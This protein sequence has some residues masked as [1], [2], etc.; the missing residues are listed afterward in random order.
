MCTIYTSYCFPGTGYACWIVSTAVAAQ[1]FFD[2]RRGL[3]M[4]VSSSGLSIGVLVWPSFMRFTI[5]TYTFRGALVL[6]AAANM[7]GFVL[8]ALLRQPHFEDKETK[9]AT[10]VEMET[11]CVGS[12]ESESRKEDITVAIK[13]HF[14]V[15]VS[16]PPDEEYKEKSLLDSCNM[17]KEVSKN[18]NQS[19]VICY[20]DE[21]LQVECDHCLEKDTSRRKGDDDSKAH[22]SVRENHSGDVNEDGWEDIDLDAQLNHHPIYRP[23]CSVGDTQSAM[24]T[25]DDNATGDVKRRQN[26]LLSCLTCITNVL[27]F[28]LLK[29]PTFSLYVVAAALIHFGHMVP[30]SFIPIRV[31]EGGSS[32]QSAALLVTVMG[33][34][35]GTGRLFFGWVGDFRCSDRKLMFAV[36]NIVVGC[37]SAASYVIQ[38]YNVLVAYCMVFAL[39]SGMYTNITIPDPRTVFYWEWGNS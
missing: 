39:M 22:D 4:A 14:T 26:G 2:K 16:E 28:S 38:D 8:S 25:Y 9:S 20:G 1:H 13:S 33:I 30:Y 35:S 21:Y 3:A 31:I 29:N 36:A 15:Y 7:H 19:V 11:F 5:A 17:A 27:D 23:R 24:E 10:E 34:G 6:L 12:D 32:K 37:I 18:D